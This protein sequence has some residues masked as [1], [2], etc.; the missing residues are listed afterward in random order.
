MFIAGAL[1]PLLS[2]DSD[3]PTDKRPTIA[4]ASIVEHAQ[5][6]NIGPETARCGVS[7]IL[8]VWR[9]SVA[10]VTRNRQ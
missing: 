9:R 2:P 7:E 4:M 8:I 6:A 10:S 1:A 3:E 5:V